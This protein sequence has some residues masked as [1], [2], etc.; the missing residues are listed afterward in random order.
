MERHGRVGEVDF[1]VS[2]PGFC[3]FLLL[4]L[5][6]LPCGAIPP[7]HLRPICIPRWIFH[8]LQD[9]GRVLSLSRKEEEKFRQLEEDVYSPCPT[10]PA[11]V[12]GAPLGG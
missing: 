11:P 7:I 8:I 10:A 12:F 4:L 1:E 2:P 6:L 9:F 5:L 3:F